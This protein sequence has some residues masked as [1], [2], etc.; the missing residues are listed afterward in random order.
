MIAS[1]NGVC[2]HNTVRSDSASSAISFYY[3][4][5]CHWLVSAIE[6]QRSHRAQ[7]QTQTRDVGTVGTGLEPRYTRQP[8]S[9]LQ[10]RFCIS[11]TLMGTIVQP[12][13]N[14]Y[15]YLRINIPVIIQAKMY[16]PK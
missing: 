2:I 1:I 12:T 9:L 5:L 14:G 7:T 15:Y 13:L 3:Y 10:E 16:K 4:L 8:S 6:L 11:V